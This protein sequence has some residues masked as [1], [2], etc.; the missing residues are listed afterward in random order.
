MPVFFYLDP[1]FLEDPNMAGIHTL[2]LS[3]SFFRADRD[4]QKLPA[5]LRD[6]EPGARLHN[7]EPLTTQPGAAG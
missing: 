2:T 4:S 6:L 7:P 1:E 5:Y 3:Y